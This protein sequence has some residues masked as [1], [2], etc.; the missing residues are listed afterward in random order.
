VVAQKDKQI[1]QLQGDVSLLFSL[2]YDLRGKLEKK[3]GEEFS[4]PVDAEERQKAEEER[5]QAFAKDNTDRAAAMDEYFKRI[6]DKPTDKAK[7]TR[8]KKKREFVVLKNKNQNPDDPN[9]Q[10]TH[11]L[12]DVGESYYDK[13][14][15]RSG[16]VSWG[17]DHDRG[18]W[19]VKRNVGPTEW[20]KGAGQFQTFTKVDLIALANAPYSDDGRT[21]RGRTFL[22]R[23]KREIARGFPS[24]KTAESRV[25]TVS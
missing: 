1:D 6:T 17:F 18:M 4:D 3:F 9:A 13:V 16:I 5:A 21:S 11:N 8:L 12:M 23:L 2:V 19:W 22:A 25:K 10:A 24:M 7:T 15:N 20:Y 14:G